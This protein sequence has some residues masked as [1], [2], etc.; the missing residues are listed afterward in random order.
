M[1]G[2]FGAHG[3]GEKNTEFFCWNFIGRYHVVNLGIDGI[4]ILKY[5]HNL[6][7]VW[8]V[9]RQG[10]YDSEQELGKG[11]LEQGTERSG[12]DRSGRAV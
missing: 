9:R 7:Y 10:W 12:A 3:R 1:I 2:T 11:P 5:K 4:L 6:W 8:R